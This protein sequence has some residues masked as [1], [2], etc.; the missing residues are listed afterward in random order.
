MYNQHLSGKELAA[1]KASLKQLPRGPRYK[2]ICEDAM[3]ANNG[4]LYRYQASARVYVGNPEAHSTDDLV[5]LSVMI[6]KALD[7]MNGRTQTFASGCDKEGRIRAD[8]SYAGRTPDQYSKWI[9]LT[10]PLGDKTYF[11]GVSSS[12]NSS[13]V[14]FAF[15]EQLIANLECV[16]YDTELD[17]EAIR[18][19]IR[20][21]R[22]IKEPTIGYQ[23][24]HNDYKLFVGKPPAEEKQP[25]P[26]PEP[27][28]ETPLIEVIKPDEGSSSSDV[29]V[30]Q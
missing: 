23:G 22:I 19:D 18:Y 12:A 15:R 29:V 17:H 25:E 4:K 3:G 30:V 10:G 26:E 1:A 7:E 13:D 14:A 6:E 9:R 20:V 21:K 16:I 24:T 27:E 11:M 28:P 2:K 5:G 8:Q